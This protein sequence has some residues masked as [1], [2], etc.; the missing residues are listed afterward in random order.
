M[1]WLDDL[2][3]SD[4]P[5]PPRPKAAG[6]PASYR[7][8]TGPTALKPTVGRCTQLGCFDDHGLCTYCGEVTR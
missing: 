5:P 4:N 8:V 6:D 7:E 1:S 3:R 2:L